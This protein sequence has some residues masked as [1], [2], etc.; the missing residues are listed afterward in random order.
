M[1]NGSE[2]ERTQA[3][4]KPALDERRLAACIGKSVFVRGDVVCSGDL[5]IDGKLE[6]T[7]EVGDHGLTIGADA[8]IEADL[9][10]RTI[11][12]DG[13]VLGNV[14]AREKLDLRATGFVEG[15]VFAYRFAMADGA[16]LQGRVETDRER[17]P[18]SCPSPEQH[19]Q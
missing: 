15:D 10:A 13:T 3:Q 5:T 11:T 14:T 7:I 19:R 9:V 17:T 12:I 18:S 8:T 4:V 6:G 1:L 2:R 16:V